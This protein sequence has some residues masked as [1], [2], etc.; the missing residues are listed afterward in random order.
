MVYNVTTWEQFLRA[1]TIAHDPDDPDDDIIEIMADMDWN[2]VTMSNPIY[3]GG[4]KTIN[5]NNH[6]IYNLHDGRS[7]GS[8]LIRNGDGST[9][10]VYGVTWN[11]INFDNIFIVLSNNGAFWG[12][13]SKS[14]VFNDCTF[15]CQCLKELFRFCTLNRCAVTFENLSANNTPFQYVDSN[16][17]WYSVKIRKTATADTSSMFKTMDTCYIEGKIFC[18]ATHAGTLGQLANCCV[19]IQ[20]DVPVY[21]ITNSSSSTITVYNTDKI[22][23]VTTHVATAIGVTDT[24]MHDASYLESIG[25]AIIAQAGE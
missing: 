6:T 1:F 2:D 25:F 21:R 20:T 10:N 7:T 11:K 9:H 5:G 16:F 4:K 13:N 3:A 12:N 8:P 19:N 14:M 24:Q 23:S 18:S 15:V 17:C 22:P